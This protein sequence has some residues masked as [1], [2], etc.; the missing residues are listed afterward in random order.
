MTG[1]PGNMWIRNREAALERAA[2][3]GGWVASP[4]AGVAGGTIHRLMKRNLK[5]KV[6]GKTL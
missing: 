3:H 4:R 2:K 5:L 1:K 6:K